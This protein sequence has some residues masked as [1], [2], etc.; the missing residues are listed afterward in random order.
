MA[1]FLFNEL[2]G[3]TLLAM[4]LKQ[5]GPAPLLGKWNALGG[6]IEPNETP[7]QAMEREFY[8]E[9]GAR[10]TAWRKFCVLSSANGDPCPGVVH[11]FTSHQPA[12]LHQM[13]S[14]IIGWQNV[15]VI[16]SRAVRFAI[17]PNLLW[18]IPLALDKDHPTAT[19]IENP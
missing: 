9:T 1:G 8:E 6:K 12:A 15:S 14:E 10:V 19:V 11:F 16:T 5:K 4:V 13:G 17:V 2:Q 18:L 3:E 7:R